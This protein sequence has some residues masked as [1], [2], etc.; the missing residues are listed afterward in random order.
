MAI[1]FHQVQTYRVYGDGVSTVIQVISSNPP[2]A[3]RLIEGPSRVNYSWS[4]DSSSGL[5]TVIFASPL[6]DASF[7][8][9]TFEV[10]I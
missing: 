9:Y 6:L 5:V 7:G 10:E 8:L 2:S 3:V 1:V 4:Y